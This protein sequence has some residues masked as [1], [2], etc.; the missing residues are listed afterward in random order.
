M[1][2]WKRQGTVEPHQVKTMYVK[3]KENYVQ[4]MHFLSQEAF[5]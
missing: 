3:A 4:Q 5:H 2:K 1:W